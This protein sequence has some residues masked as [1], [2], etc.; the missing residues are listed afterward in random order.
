MKTPFT[1]DGTAYPNVYVTSLRRSFSVLDGENA[2]RVL[3]GAMVRDIIGTYYNY[4]MEI[5]QN[6]SDPAE[7]DR[8][9]EVLSAPVDSHVIV[10]P[11]GQSTLTFRA[12]VANGEDELMKCYDTLNTWDSLSVSFV[13]MSPQRRPA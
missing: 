3:T 4:T 9:Y 13:S 7:Y 1:I 11:Y 6:E 10:V 8:L 5:S 2:G 12:Y